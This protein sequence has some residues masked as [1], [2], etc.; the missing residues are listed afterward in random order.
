MFAYCTEVLHLS[1]AEA[2]LRITVARAAR[3]HPVLLAM[4][5]DGRL[6]LTAIAKLAPHLTREN[7][8]ALL[9]RAIHR[10]KREVQELV[11]EIAPRPDAPSVMRKL[12]DRGAATAPV[13]PPTRLGPSSVPN[14]QLGP[15]RVE[16][17]TQPRRA[18]PPSQ[19]AK[20]RRPER[21][22]LSRESAAPGPDPQL[23]PHAVR[24]P[25]LAC[26]VR[27][28]RTALVRQ[29]VEPLS[30]GRYKVQFTASAELRDKLERLTALMRSAVPDGDLG[31]IIDGPSP[32][33]SSGSKPGAS[34]RRSAPRKSLGRHRHVALL[35]PHPGRRPAGRLRARWRAMPLRRRAGSSMHRARP[36]RVPPP[37]P[38][39]PRRRPFAR[40]DL[41][42][43]PRPQPLPGRDRLWPAAHGQAPARRGPSLRAAAFPGHR[44][45]GRAE[46]S[47]CPRGGIASNLETPHPHSRQAPAGRRGCRLP[48]R[49]AVCSPRE[50]AMLDI[51]RI[52]EQF[53]ITR[54][55]F[56]VLGQA[57]PKPLIYMD[58][59]AST[60]PPT[61]VLDTYKDFLE[62]SYANVHRGRHYLSEMATDRF[63]HVSDDIFRFIHGSRAGNTVILL[64][65]HHP[66]PR[67]RR[68][69]DGAP[70]GRDA[71]VADGAPLER[72]APPRA[73]PGR[74]LRR[75][76]RRHARLRR[77]RGEAA[78]STR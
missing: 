72:P 3:Q 51:R 7:R 5:R 22:G 34:R 8:E 39:R 58:H 48:R 24:Q 69:R 70:R 62:H 44:E 38:V 54:Q 12:P 28:P 6:H 15:D 13:R 47:R 14:A 61:P 30:P 16:P 53:P 2:Y 52:R 42:A 74:P 18:P 32:R 60:H 73:G 29:R 63:E 27:R 68:P 43:V 45:H 41:P 25:A 59:G 37:A 76:G 66:G 4:L 17:R 56:Q 36:A 65:E 55:R 23:C 40:R 19:R 11:A 64:R 50:T 26:P 46:S 67:P 77:P 20:S 78:R 35:A 31:A 1:E 10:S 49:P 71:R 9:G 33:S 21:R 75:E 57:E